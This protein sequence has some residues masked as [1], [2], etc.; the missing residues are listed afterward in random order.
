M[1]TT[2]IR[3]LS[4]CISVYYSGIRCLDAISSYVDIAAHIGIP[5]YSRCHT[6]CIG[7]DTDFYSN[8]IRICISDLGAMICGMSK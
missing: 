2:P 1:I 4:N 5:L 3:L 7:Y 6:Q 8:M